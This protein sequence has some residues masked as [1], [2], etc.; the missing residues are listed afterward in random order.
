MSTKGE[1]PPSPL[2]CPLFSSLP[3]LPTKYTKI[4]RICKSLFAWRQGAKLVFEKKTTAAILV[5]QTNPLGVEFLSY[6]DNLF[7]YHNSA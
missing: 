7:C 5:N 3:F 1:I 6:V 4:T 2:L